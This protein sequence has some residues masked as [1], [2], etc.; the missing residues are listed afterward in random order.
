VHPDRV[1][2]N[3]ETGENIKEERE[4]KRVRHE[5]YVNMYMTKMTSKKI[6]LP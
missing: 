5:N 6:N 2:K 3:K 4:E 1:A